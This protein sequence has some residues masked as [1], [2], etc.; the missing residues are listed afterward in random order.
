MFI[1]NQIWDRSN[2]FFLPIAQ[3][4]YQSWDEKQKINLEQPYKFVLNIVVKT[5][6]LSDAMSHIFL[7]IE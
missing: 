2:F 3:K 7:N 1:L 4:T 5:D 6:W